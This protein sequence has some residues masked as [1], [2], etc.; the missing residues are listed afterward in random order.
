MY[1][2]EINLG[3]VNNARTKIVGL[4]ERGSRVLEIGCATG[5]MTE[6]LTREH[7]CTVTAVEVD[8]E[9]A[10]RAALRGVD[11]IVG[12]VEDPDVVARL[13]GPYDAMIFSD[14]LEHLVDPGQAAGRT[15]QLHRGRHS[16]PRTRPL[17]HASD[18]CRAVRGRRAGSCLRLREHVS[19]DHA[20]SFGCPTAHRRLCSGALRVPV[21]CRRTKE[22]IPR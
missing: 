12:S 16:R 13:D 8:T 21:H 3:E 17:L 18:D 14:V 15:V 7:G 10:A 1:D 11:V 2:G 22:V 5:F 6:Y 19:G 4:I 9:A 20:A